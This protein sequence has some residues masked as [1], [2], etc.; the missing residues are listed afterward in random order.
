MVIH[1]NTYSRVV[2][3][4]KIL[5]PLLALVLLSTLFLVARTIN[6]AQNIPFA[7][8][9]VDELAREQRISA[10]RLSSVSQDGSAISLAADTARPDPGNPARMSGTGIRA[11]IDLPNG[12]RIDVVSEFAQIDTNTGLAK[13]NDTVVITTSDGYVLRTD[14]V[15][16]SLQ[17]TGVRSDSPTTVSAPIGTLSAD[18]FTLTGDGKESRPYVLVFKGRV[19]LIYDPSE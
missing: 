8:V 13:L 5:L 16:M 10:P 6:P 1:D 14:A 3:W 9:D 12:G 19:K 15:E 17:E 18:R 4:L 2:A 11:G 7:D